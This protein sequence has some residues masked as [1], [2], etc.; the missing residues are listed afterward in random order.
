MHAPASMMTV[1]SLR[2]GWGG[3]HTQAEDRQDNRQTSNYFHRYF[4]VY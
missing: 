4:S 1:G 2:F 3:Q